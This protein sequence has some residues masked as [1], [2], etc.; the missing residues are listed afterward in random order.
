[1]VSSTICSYNLVV[2]YMYTNDA[3]D[4]DTHGKLS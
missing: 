2:L 3:P 4:V 1:M